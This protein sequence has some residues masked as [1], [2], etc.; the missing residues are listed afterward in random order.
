MAVLCESTPN[1]LK[2][3]VGA[4]PAVQ[5]QEGRPRAIS[6][7]VEKMNVLAFY[8]C[9]E[10]GEK[11][12]ARLDFTPAVGVKPIVDK[13]FQIGYTNAGTPPAYVRKLTP[14]ITADPG[15]DCVQAFFRYC[16]V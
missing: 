6:L 15:A 16:V 12:E 14:V 2:L 13:A 9:D 11:V 3:E 1:S 7:H 5:K 10:I 8:F 4:G